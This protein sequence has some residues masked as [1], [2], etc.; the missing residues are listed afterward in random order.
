MD[1][2]QFLAPSTS[3]TVLESNGLNY[4]AVG[5][6]FVLVLWDFV[7]LFGCFGLVW[8]GFLHFDILELSQHWH[9][10]ASFDLYGSV[11]IRSWVTL[12]LLIKK[13]WNKRKLC[14]EALHLYKCLLTLFI[15]VLHIWLN[16]RKIL[17]CSEI[18]F[19]ALKTI[20]WHF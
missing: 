10:S 8:F 12:A 9:N 3:K 2:G 17:K 4:Y 6:V 18:F 1:I 19:T 15:K 5:F 11:A 13:K 16:K 7:C 14:S 20:L